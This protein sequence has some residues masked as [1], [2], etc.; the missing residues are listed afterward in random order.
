LTLIGLPK[1]YERA[2]MNL[3]V[4]NPSAVPL[5]GAQGELLTVSIL[6][7]PRNLERLLDR[8]GESQFPIDPQIYHDAHVDGRP[9]TL[10]EFPAYATWLDELRTLLNGCDSVRIRKVYSSYPP[11]VN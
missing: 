11:E 9:A 7:E 8:L 2:A 4:V 3:N 1:R 5:A 10:I 6:A